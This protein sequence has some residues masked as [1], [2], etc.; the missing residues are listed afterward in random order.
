MAGEGGARPQQAAPGGS[1]ITWMFV[2]LFLMLILFNPGI[3]N[4][5]GS[6]MGFLM[7]PVI[8]FSGTQPLWSIFIG[9][10]IIVIITQFIR[11][12]MTNWIRLAREQRYMSAFNK[13]VSE[14][15]KAGNEVRMRK[16]LEMQPQVMSKQ[17]DI[18]A[19]T[20]KPTIFT[21]VIFIAFFT[22]LY[23]FTAAAAVK[24]VSLPWEPAWPLQKVA[25]FPYGIALYML[26]SMTLGQAVT[27]I[28]KYISFSR[29]LR[30]LGPSA[31]DEAEASE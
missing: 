23:V 27:N 8:G 15:R 17:M 29:R 7:D 1:S 4:S 5:L 21:M 22:W 25:W 12:L 6:G 18:Q 31:A 28:L 16:L 14:A 30:A 26:F 19:Q 3:R 9:S 10:L 11:H 24:S 20:M 13:E 2:F